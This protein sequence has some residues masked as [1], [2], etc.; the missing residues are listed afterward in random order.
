MSWGD[1]VFARHVLPLVPLQLAFL[2][3][4][5]VRGCQHLENSG[6]V[7]H[8]VAV[9]VVW[10]VTTLLVVQP[11]NGAWQVAKLQATQ[12]TRS[13]ARD[14]VERH[15]PRGSTLCNFEGW[16]GDPQLNTIENLWWRFTRFTGAY[17]DQNLEP[18]TRSASKSESPYYFYA[19]QTSNE[20]QAEGS[21]AL[22][23]SRECSHV[24]LHAHPLS[25]SRIDTLV[26]RRLRD[27]ARQVATFDPQVYASVFDPLDAYYIPLAGW[28]ASTAGP[29]IEIWDVHQYHSEPTAQS[30][31]SLLSQALSMGADT[32]AHRGDRPAARVDVARALSLEP[33]N[34]H[35]LEVLA[36]IERDTGD[37]ESAA[38]AYLEI[39]EINPE[40]SRAPEGL[41]LLSV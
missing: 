13:S 24:I 38:S 5:V 19:G 22:I 2:G 18:L 37:L 25:Y 31:K 23:H 33:H 12:D 20:D 29:R 14:W 21:I 9:A 32:K 6:R 1:L 15:V 30:A 8:R 34:T 27:E 11:V 36:G 35:A 39:L 40:D 26:R 7:S 4:S 10:A 28:E 41:A 17:G 3:D 16:A